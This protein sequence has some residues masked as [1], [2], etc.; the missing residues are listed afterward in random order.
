MVVIALSYSVI[1][2][3]YIMAGPS[4]MHRT[5]LHTFILHRLSSPLTALEFSLFNVGSHRAR[6]D[7]ALHMFQKSNVAIGPGVDTGSHEAPTS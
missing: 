7:R 2:P 4:F 6:M 1:A 3:T 5:R